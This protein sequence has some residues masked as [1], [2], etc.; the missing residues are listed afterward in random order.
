MF[1]AFSESAR[2]VIFSARL[3]AG[4][5]KFD[6]IDPHHLLLGF[7]HEDGSDPQ[8]NLYKALELEGSEPVR[9]REQ[10][11]SKP[12][13]DSA[14]ASNLLVRFSREGRRPDSLPQAVD[15]PLA[16]ESCA[17]LTLAHEL[18]AGGKV[19]PLHLLWSLLADKESEITT[20]LAE[21]GVTQEQV[22]IAIRKR[23]TS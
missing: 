8:S 1:D 9:L 21:N 19:T 23:E 15:M 2:R 4:R 5:L 7:V 14:T 11:S 3:E 12:L 13:L 17:V 16:L 6:T 20:C 10:R 18:A 22:E